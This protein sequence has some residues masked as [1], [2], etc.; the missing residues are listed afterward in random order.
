[1]IP[2]GGPE[3]PDRSTADH[4]RRALWKGCLHLRS[5][6]GRSL[7]AALTTLAC[8]CTA[9]SAAA[10]VPGLVTVR[11]EGTPQTLLAPTIVTTEAADFHPASDPVAHTCPGTSAARA[12]E[13][14]TGGTWSGTYFASFGDYQVNTI[15]G[16]AHPAGATDGSY[17]AFWVNNMPAQVG[18][19]QQQLNPGDQILFFPDCFGTCPAGFV[20]PAVLGVSAPAVVQSG[21]PF[22]ASVVAY[23]NAGGPAKA[24]TGATITGGGA[25]STSGP[26]GQ[27]TVTLGTPGSYLLSVTAPNSVRTETAI[28]VHNGNDGNCGTT[29]TTPGTPAA[30]SPPAGTGA[31]QARRPRGRPRPPGAGRAARTDSAG[32]ST[33]PRRPP[34]CRSPRV[35]NTATGR[36]RA[37]STARSPPIRRDCGRSGFG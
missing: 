1:M 5:V 3:K 19:C 35:V 21:T 11:V 33:R 30:G 10:P 15:L 37:R 32:R 6:L 27:A 36:A 4:S 26:G 23:P 20:S 2:V 22:T 25:S 17:W 12:L 28:C 8:W 31:G 7:V 9:A 29:K 18:I 16:E 13:V 24:L 14:A 34:A